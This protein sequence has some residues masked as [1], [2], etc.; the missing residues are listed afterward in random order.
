MP[1]HHTAPPA[2]T[3]ATTWFALLGAHRDVVRQER[4][5]V[6]LVAL[7]IA[8]VLSLGRRT[9][10]RWLA[11][12][13]VGRADWTAWY[14][15]FSRGRLH[16]ATFTIPADYRPRLAAAQ[17]EALPAVADAGG[18]ASAAGAAADQP[19]DALRAGRHREGGVPGA[20]G[21]LGVGKPD[22]RQ[23]RGI[24]VAFQCRT[25]VTDRIEEGAPVTKDHRLGRAA[26]RHPGF[27]V[28]RFP[29]GV[30]DEIGCHRL[31]LRG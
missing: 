29:I 28:G 30:N 14:R 17:A 20:P 3:L 16:L 2:P 21:G 26:E 8:D 10:T 19:A 6:R 7:A 9:P 11:T 24:P 23:D 27:A 31:V 25:A 18:G 12:L 13:G 5:F 1:P 22:D 4:V 15:L